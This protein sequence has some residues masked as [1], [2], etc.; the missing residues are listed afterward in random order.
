VL[1]AA[2]ASVLLAA[3]LAAGCDRRVEPLVPGE[4]PATPDLSRIFPPESAEPP[5]PDAAPTLPPPPPRTGP[6]PPGDTATAGAD[7][8]PVRGTVQVAAE[9]AGRVP[10][11]AALFVFARAA[12]G[13]PPLAAKRI[14]SPHFPLAFELGPQDRMVAGRPFEGPLQLSARL[15]ADGNATTRSPGDLQGGSAAPVEP[16]ASGVAIVHDQVL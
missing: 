7:G 5:L 3:A 6:M 9:L 14:E 1:R 8:A 11:G 10:A 16:G 2:A 12:G 13:G 15:D 4:E